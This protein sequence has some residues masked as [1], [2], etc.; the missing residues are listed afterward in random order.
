MNWLNS[1]IFDSTPDEISDELFE[2]IVSGNHIKVERII[3]KGHSSPKSGWYDQTENEWV[4]VLEGEAIIE[5][6][7]QAPVHLVKGSYLN[8]LAHTRHKVSW[9]HPDMETIWLAIHYT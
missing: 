6:E 8:I 3:S 9:T 7:H 1:N 5:L 2:N 4:I